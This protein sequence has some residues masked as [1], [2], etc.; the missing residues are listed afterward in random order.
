MRKIGTARLGPCNQNG[1]ICM[2]DGHPRI[3]NR[4]KGAKDL[5]LEARP[6]PGACP[7]CISRVGGHHS[8]QQRG[9]ICGRTPPFGQEKKIFLHLADRMYVC[10]YVCERIDQQSTEGNRP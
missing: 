9:G 8:S 2:G 7:G 3:K 1:R 5:W 10:T 6:T 4:T